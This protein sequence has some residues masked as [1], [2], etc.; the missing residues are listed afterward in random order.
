MP[1]LLFSTWRLPTVLTL[2]QK[3]D[4]IEAQEMAQLFAL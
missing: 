4:K 1:S 2:W 3:E